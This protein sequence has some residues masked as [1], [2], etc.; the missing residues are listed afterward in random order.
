M[1]RDLGN[2]SAVVPPSARLRLAFDASSVEPPTGDETA[3]LRDVIANSRDLAAGQRDRAAE[4]QQEAFLSAEDV[5]DSMIRALLAASAVSRDHAAADRAA[6]ASD[7]HLAAEDRASVA[8]DSSQALIERQRLRDVSAAARDLAADIRDREAEAREQRLLAVEDVRDSAIRTLLSAGGVGRG[9]AA[10]DRAGAASDRHLA[11]E[12]RASASAEVG[13]ARLELEQ[14]HL[15][16]LTGAQRRDLG[17]KTL[18]REI[19]RSRRSGEPFALA[20]IDVDGLKELNDREGHA[21]GDTLLQAV[22]V[23]LRTALRSYDPIVRLGGDEFLCGFTNT[24]LETSRRRVEQIRA[25]LASGSPNASVSV[26]IAMLGERDTLEMLI[27]RADADMYS[28]KERRRIG[29]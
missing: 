7:R 15:D 14:A 18:Q 2:G 4:E 1:G 19:E 21:A 16:G 8:A 28:R 26:G 12:D 29:A 5:R 11:A 3:A 17:R 13:Q 20:F 27:A 24:D 6:A 22:V 25:G 10:A 9:Q 23:A